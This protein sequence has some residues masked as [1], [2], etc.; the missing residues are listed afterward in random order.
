[1]A[2]ALLDRLILED[3]CCSHQLSDPGIKTNGGTTRLCDTD[4]A[5]DQAR[6]NGLDGGGHDA[7]QWEAL[8]D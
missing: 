8:P 5:T 1:M 4:C 7:P 2:S 3:T 6:D